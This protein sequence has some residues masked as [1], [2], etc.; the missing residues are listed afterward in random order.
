VHG[1]KLVAIK[2]S[3]K[4][5]CEGGHPILLAAENLGSAK[6]SGSVG[7]AHDFGEKR[8]DT[9]AE[10]ISRVMELGICRILTETDAAELAKCVDLVAGDAEKGAVNHEL[11]TLRNRLH[12]SETRGASASQEV[13]KTGFDLIIR[14]VRENEGIGFRPCGAFFKERQAQFASGQFDGFF[15]SLS[16]FR[17]PAASVL[18]AEPSEGSVIKNQTRIRIRTPPAQRVVEMADNEVF[19]T[20]LK[21]SMEKHHR[22]TAAGDADEKFFSFGNTAHH[23]GDG[24]QN[25][26]L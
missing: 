1:T 5:G 16:V 10:F 19:V 26:G 18:N 14:M 20:Q 11:A 13:E 9:E 15:L 22:V 6:N 3:R 7:I 25:D 24:F 17:R 23:F 12:A 4:L 21:K 2:L 8:H